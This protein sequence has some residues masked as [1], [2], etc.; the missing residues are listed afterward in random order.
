M[1]WLRF[2]RNGVWHDYREPKKFNIFQKGVHRKPTLILYKSL[3]KT[4][5]SLSAIPNNP[6]AQ[7]IQ[8]IRKQFRKNRYSE[9]PKLVKKYLIT[10]YEVHPPQF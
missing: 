5:L 7:V 3:L 1:K 6:S 8:E 10:A 9:S 4:S 2:F